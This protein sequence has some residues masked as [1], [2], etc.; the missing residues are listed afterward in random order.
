[1]QGAT[2]YGA[3][4]DADCRFTRDTGYM[5]PELVTKKPATAAVIVTNDWSAMNTPTP[6]P[7]RVH[8]CTRLPSAAAGWQ[9]T[10]DAVVADG[11]PCHHCASIWGDGPRD[12]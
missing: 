12:R 5:V 3:Q 9:C 1:M 11:G 7:P 4:G 6:L 8:V 2:L 10:E